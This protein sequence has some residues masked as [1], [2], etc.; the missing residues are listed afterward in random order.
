MQGR[1]VFSRP[2]LTYTAL[3]VSFDWFAC[4]VYLKG[5]RTGDR[6]LSEIKA[7]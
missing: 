1:A 4:F 3:L 6:V 2:L 7:S 5:K